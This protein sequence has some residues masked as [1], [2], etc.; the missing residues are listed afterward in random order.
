MAATDDP[1]QRG[2]LQVALGRAL[3]AQGDYPGAGAVAEAVLDTLD[4]SDPR[5][6]Q[7][8]VVELIATSVDRR[9]HEPAVAR[10]LPYIT[11]G[12][13]GQ[14][15][16]DPGLCAWLA[17]V[18][19]SF[20][21]VPQATALLERAL[22][23]S[24]LVDDS[25]PSIVS[26]VRA[27]QL[28]MDRAADAERT[29]TAAMARALE[30]GLPMQYEQALHS[31]ALARMRAG[32]V[33]EALGDALASMP[34]PGATWTLHAPYGA[35]LLTAIHLE[36]GDL[37]AARGAVALGWEWAGNDMERAN[38]HEAESHLHRAEG[39]PAAA[40]ESALAAG[41]AMAAFGLEAVT[42]TCL[43]WQSAA[44]FAAA[45]LGDRE[46]AAELG[47]AEL[48]R[49]E[50]VG[51]PGAIGIARHAWALGETGDRRIELLSAAAEELGR[52]EQRLAEA[53]ALVALGAALRERGDAV[54]ARV[55]LS[56]ALDLAD[57]C[58]SFVLVAQARDELRLAGARPRRAALHGV[59]ALTDSE[60]RVAERAAAG[61]TNAEIARELFVSVK[62]VEGT[63]GRAYRKLGIRSRA[64]LRD[65]LAQ[66]GQP[67]TR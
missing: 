51:L 10:A 14:L 21:A 63:L 66:P 38:V 5:A 45:Q 55:P 2:H 43:P 31:R 57:R 19:S 28:N 32:G 67:R 33:R 4:P 47:R 41:A 11:A 8:L 26:F 49:A 13:A 17:A 36:L 1:E 46:Q 9:L 7:L 30:H 23:D 44:A 39:D 40:L 42:P 16:E 29:A 50:P 58:G 12:F 35:A 60:R 15:P 48:L 62:T 22:R 3:L 34:G 59:A 53:R 52:S 54:A 6:E 25:H 37:A 24:P 61:R 27:A 65:A 56:A 18:L 20:G 64:A